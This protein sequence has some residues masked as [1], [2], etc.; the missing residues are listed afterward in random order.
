MVRLH[1]TSVSRDDGKSVAGRLSALLFTVVVGTVFFAADAIPVLGG[2]TC[3]SLTRLR[4]VGGRVVL[5][6]LPAMAVRAEVLTR[7]S[8]FVALD[9][10]RHMPVLAFFC[11]VIEEVGFSSEILPVMS[12][13]TVTP[14][15]NMLLVRVGA[16][17][18]LEVEDIKVVILFHLIQEVHPELV[19]AVGKR[20]EG[21]ILTVRKF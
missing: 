12:I 9:E 6:L 10:V 14:R 5:L 7:T 18:G 4:S 17:D 20:A 2:V 16:P 8:V 15:M 19:L 3:R 13:Y 11:R 21:S 1:T